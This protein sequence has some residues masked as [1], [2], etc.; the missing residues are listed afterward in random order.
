VVAQDGDDRHVEVAAGV[1]EDLGLLGLAVRGQVAGEQQQV[2]LLVEAGERAQGLVAVAG[3]AVDVAGR[4]D[5]HS[6]GHVVAPTHLGYRSPHGPQRR[7]VQ[8]D[9]REP[10]PRG[11]RLREADVRYCLSGSVASWARG[12][13][14]TGQRR[15]PDRRPAGHRQGGRRAGGRRHAVRGAAEGW[16]VKL[17][18]GDVPD[19]PHPHRHRLRV[20]R[21]DPAALRGDARR[22]ARRAGRADGG[23]PD[24]EAARVRRALPRLHRRAARRARLREQIDWSLLREKTCHSPYARG[25]FALLEALDIIPAEATPTPGKGP[26]VKV[27]QT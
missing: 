14:E 8:A 1:G 19:R 25:F 6:V 18:D 15:R 20:G 21:G 9:R 13:P 5:P 11:R 7:R 2:G 27:V 10:A 23:R 22:V 24:A 12:G 4:G 3:L 17:S 26:S 16:L